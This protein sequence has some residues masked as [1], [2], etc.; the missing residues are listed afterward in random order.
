MQL[1]T[2]HGM[3]AILQIHL[4]VSADSNI[5][6]ISFMKHNDMLSF[7]TSILFYSKNTCKLFS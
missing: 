1:V 6:G 7:E 5:M 3:N 4:A 2:Q